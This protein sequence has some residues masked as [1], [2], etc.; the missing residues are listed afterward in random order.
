M[1]WLARI[2]AALY[3]AGYVFYV[4]AAGIAAW[5]R[6][7]VFD[8]WTYMAFQIAFYGPFWPLFLRA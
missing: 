6:M 5:P 8:F 2:L 4:A 1:R 7:G 3:V